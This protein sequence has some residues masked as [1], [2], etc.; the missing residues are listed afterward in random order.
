MVGPGS[1]RPWCWNRRP[2]VLHHRL[3]RDLAV[4]F[5]RMYQQPLNK[6]RGDR[7]SHILAVYQGVPKFPQQMCINYPTPDKL[8]HLIPP[9]GGYAK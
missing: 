6:K 2:A 8:T 1:R 3:R 4:S 9:R 7:T 5:L